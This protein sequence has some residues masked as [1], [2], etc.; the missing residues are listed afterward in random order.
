LPVVGVTG[1]VTAVAE[2]SLQ[3]RHG[4]RTVTS[5]AGQ[6]T[7]LPCYATIP[8]VIWQRKLK[9]TTK[10]LSTDDEI[11]VDNGLVIK[12]FSSRFFLDATGKGEQSLVI[13][14]TEKSDGG[15]YECVEEGGLGLRHTVSL[16]VFGESL[17]F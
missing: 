4:N 16:E 10:E 15:T 8:P 12:Q 7:V 3:K 2:N 1:Y 11:L 9:A 5:T 6:T 14:R 17:L 13:A